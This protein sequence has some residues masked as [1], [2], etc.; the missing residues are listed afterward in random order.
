LNGKMLDR[1]PVDG[2]GKPIMLDVDG[3]SVP[4]LCVKSE[5]G[6]IVLYQLTN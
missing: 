3:N 1:M 5:G 4:E 6:E 2:T